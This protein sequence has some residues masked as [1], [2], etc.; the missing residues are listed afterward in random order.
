MQKLNKE[1][2]IAINGGGV[3][4]WVVLGIGTLLVFLGG[5]LDGFTRPLSCND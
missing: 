3:S 1:E 2:M 5:L 4:G